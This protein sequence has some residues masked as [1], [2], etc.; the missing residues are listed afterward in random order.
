MEERETQ[1]LLAQT[2]VSLCFEVSGAMTSIVNG[3]IA[4]EG[5]AKVLEPDAE[6]LVLKNYYS[7]S[8][9]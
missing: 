9:C 7:L 4:Q 2:F 3:Q 6:F 1:V 5:I 8:Y